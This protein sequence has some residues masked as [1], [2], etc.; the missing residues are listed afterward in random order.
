MG[1]QITG[2]S[3]ISS[4]PSVISLH[5]QSTNPP[6]PTKSQE[7][8]PPPPPPSTQT[9][10]DNYSFDGFY[11]SSNGGLS[12]SNGT[13][14]LRRQGHVYHTLITKLVSTIILIKLYKYGFASC[15]L[16][17]LRT[18]FVLMRAQNAAF[19]T[20]TFFPLS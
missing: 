4:V 9:V 8:C 1:H 15:F 2:N 18:S 19:W 3:A 10:T 17:A 11:Q 12:N 16:V 5:L 6:L 14:Q 7:S 13:S 20:K